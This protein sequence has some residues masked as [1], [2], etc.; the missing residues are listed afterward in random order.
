MTKTK[1][2]EE[3]L[4]WKAG[5]CLKKPRGSLTAEKIESSTKL[6]IKVLTVCEVCLQVKQIVYLAQ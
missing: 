4:Q 5:F 2:Y 1:Y 3:L 6:S